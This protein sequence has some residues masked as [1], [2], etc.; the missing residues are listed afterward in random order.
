M[1]QDP[2]P[3]VTVLTNE[4]M[5]N[6]LEVVAATTAARS[7]TGDD[8]SDSLSQTFQVDSTFDLSMIYLGY[9]YDESADPS[10]SLVNIE[11]FEVDNVAAQELVPGTSILTLSGVTLPQLSGTAT[12]VLDST[13]TLEETSGSNGYA[14]RISGGRSPGFEW[15]RTGS[16]SGS[17]YSGGQAYENSEEKFGGERD[18]VLG[19]E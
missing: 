9:E 2:S 5:S 10:H 8:S 3:D 11:I 14:L 16:S 6:S 1:N 18:F 15:V 7:L 4:P 13:I 17:V 12:I 19:L